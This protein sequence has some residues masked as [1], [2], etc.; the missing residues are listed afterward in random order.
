MKDYIKRA[1]TNRYKVIEFCRGC[2]RTFC[3]TSYFPFQIYR[4]IEYYL[5][6]NK[7]KPFH[8]IPYINLMLNWKEV[9]HVWDDDIQIYP[10]EVFASEWINF[11]THKYKENTIPYEILHSLDNSNICKLSHCFVNTFNEFDENVSV[12]LDYAE[13][14]VFKHPEELEF[15]DINGKTPLELLLESKKIYSDS[16]SYEKLKEILTPNNS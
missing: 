15:R 4:G 9:E 8:S 2:K 7:D 11:R 10:Y 16:K 14:W 1:K 3:P 6:I 12:I 5:E 13:K